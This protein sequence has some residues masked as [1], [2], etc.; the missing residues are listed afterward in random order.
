MPVAGI[1]YQVLVK[2]NLVENIEAVAGT[3]CAKVLARVAKSEDKVVDEV[4]MYQHIA[5][6]EPEAEIITE[7]GE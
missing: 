3:A 5:A 4:E 7:K 6:A 2:S 1:G